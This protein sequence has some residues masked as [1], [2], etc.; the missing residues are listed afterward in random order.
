MKRHEIDSSPFSSVNTEYSVFNFSRRNPPDLVLTFGLNQSAPCDLYNPTTNRLKPER[1]APWTNNSIII[2]KKATMVHLYDDPDAHSMRGADGNEFRMPTEEAQDD[3]TVGMTDEELRSAIN[4][5]S[6]LAP[7]LTQWKL[8]KDNDVYVSVDKARHDLAVQADKEFGFILS[9]L[10]APDGT[11]VLPPDL[12]D[13]T[14][15]A[16]YDRL[17]DWVFGPNSELFQIFQKRIPGLRN[18]HEV[19]ARCLATFFMQA[20]VDDAADSDEFLCDDDPE[21]GYASKEEYRLYW[22]AVAD[23]NMPDRR[24]RGI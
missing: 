5:G 10:C 21:S 16:I 8:S 4:E 6:K 2:N 17:V 14:N 23:A 22:L 1:T 18:N 9:K 11:G 24:G 19:F 20:R 3:W 13:M 15:D 7:K 12:T